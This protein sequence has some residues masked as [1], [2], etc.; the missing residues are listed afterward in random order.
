MTKSNRAIG[1]EAEDM[2]C[3]Y[4]QKHGWQ[5]LDRNVYVGKAE[6]DVIAQTLFCIA[7]IEVKMRSGTQFGHPIE[8]VDEGK[9]ERVF[10]A[11]EQ[12]AHTHQIQLPLRFDVIGILKRKGHSPEITHFED[13]YR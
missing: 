13:A 8:F 11:A 6:I 5:I 10:S 4:L 7:F 9:I 3:E 12:W 1:D 2:A